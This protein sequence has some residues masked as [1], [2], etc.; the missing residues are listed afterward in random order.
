MESLQLARNLGPASLYRILVIIGCGLAIAGDEDRG[1]NKSPQILHRVKRNTAPNLLSTALIGHSIT[2]D[3]ARVPFSYVIRGADIDGDTLVY[4]KT[5]GA[6]EA[7]YG[8]WT[9]DRTTGMLHYWPYQDAYGIDYLYFTVTEQRTDSLPALSTNS[10]FAIE[11]RPVPDPPVMFL[12]YNG[13]DMITDIRTPVTITMEENSGD[14]VAY[15]DLNMLLGAYDVDPPDNHTAVVTTQPMHG[16]VTLSTQN[17]D[18]LNYPSDCHLPAQNQTIRNDSNTSLPPTIP[19]NLKLPHP[20]DA[21]SWVTTVLTYKPSLAYYGN[22]SFQVIIYDNW[23]QPS[24][25]PNNMLTVIVQVLNNPCQNGATCFGHNNGDPTCNHTQRTTG[26]DQFSYGCAC[27]RGWTGIHCQYD[28]NECYST[29][30]VSPYVCVDHFDGYSC[31]CPTNNRYCKPQFPR[32]Q[33]A[34]ITAAVGIFIATLTIFIIF[35]ARR[36]QERPIK[37]QPRAQFLAQNLSF[38]F[39]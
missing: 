4:F 3:H 35:M 33:M 13:N 36:R 10:T 28:F 5:S 19:C 38:V 6:P 14:N 15:E 17:T 2:E 27:T 31:D 8:N 21:M 39:C 1:D 29:P 18:V 32:W 12:S 20:P 26:F 24:Q 23:G 34:L 11:V 7:Q 37:R 9:L 25:T 30:C 22:D 16:S